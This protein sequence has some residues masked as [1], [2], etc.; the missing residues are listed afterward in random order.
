[1]GGCG[2]H[3]RSAQSAPSVRKHPNVEYDTPA[4]RSSKGKES[5]RISLPYY[6]ESSD[7][8]LPFSPELT[9]MNKSTDVDFYP[10]TDKK[11]LSTPCLYQSSLHNDRKLESSLNIDVSVTMDDNW[12]SP[13]DSAEECSSAGK[14]DFLNPVE[15]QP[16]NLGFGVTNLP[17]E[18][19]EQLRKLVIAD[20]PEAKD[21]AEQLLAWIA[22]LPTLE[23]SMQ[24]QVV[25]IM[26]SSLDLS[27]CGKENNINITSELVFDN[28]ACNWSSSS[29]A[30]MECGQIVAQGHSLKLIGSDSG[31][32]LILSDG[33]DLLCESIGSLK[34][35][36]KMDMFEFSKRQV[37]K[38]RRKSFA[39]SQFLEKLPSLS[40]SLASSK[41]ASNKELSIS[42][43][44]AISPEDQEDSGLESMTSKIDELD[45]K[46]SESTQKLTELRKKSLDLLTAGDDSGDSDDQGKNASFFSVE[47]EIGHFK[48][49]KSKLVDER[50]QIIAKLHSRLIEQLSY[51]PLSTSLT[52]SEIT[53]VRE[54]MVVSNVKLPYDLMKSTSGT[55]SLSAVSNVCF[56]EVNAQAEESE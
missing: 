56:P 9:S 45:R 25:K 52:E 44:Y 51:T 48:K 41:R 29:L 36:E 42:D 16:Q 15:Q 10:N 3:I 19:L 39:M 27:I 40:Q 28:G 38:S 17:P 32:S 14:I 13:A 21:V 55:G 8:H 46:I 26:S 2:S 11:P 33:E 23:N 34:D 37:I 53:H 20:C 24:L 4:G 54:S 50:D 7:G 43:R 22:K 31:E 12:T 18:I 49:H 35:D 6:I 47:R 30:S 1:M 5:L